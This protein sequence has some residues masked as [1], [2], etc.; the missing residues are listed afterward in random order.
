ML[1][2][3]ELYTP[4]LTIKILDH[5]NFGRKPTVGLHSIHSLA[6]YR[7]D[8]SKKEMILSYSESK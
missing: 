5:R 1:P 2:K 4:P 3:E 8:R 7:I 6:K